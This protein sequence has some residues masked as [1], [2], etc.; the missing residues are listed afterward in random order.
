M[1]PNE[2][3]IAIAEACG[4]TGIYT[5]SDKKSYGHHENQTTTLREPIPGYLNDLNAMHE[6][7]KVLTDNFTTQDFQLARFIGHLENVVSRDVAIP[8]V[9]WSWALVTS[10]AAQRAEAFLRTLDLWKDD[11]SHLNTVASSTAPRETPK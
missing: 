4:W 10:T 5:G 8:P 6:A 7:E 9:G 11:A 2:Q 3:Q 1:T